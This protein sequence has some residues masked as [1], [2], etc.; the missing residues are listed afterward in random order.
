MSKVCIQEIDSGLSTDYYVL[1]GY[2]TS[3]AIYEFEIYTSL[4]IL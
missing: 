1:Y 2:D 4:S 3:S